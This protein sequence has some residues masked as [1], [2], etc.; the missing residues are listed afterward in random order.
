ME[1]RL[2][3]IC[4][5]LA[6]L[7]PVAG[8][9]SGVIWGGRSL[10]LPAFGPADS[11][12]RFLSGLLC[13]IGIGFWT[14]IPDI[15]RSG[16]RFQLLTILIVA[17]GFARALGLFLAGPAGPLMTGALSLELVIAPALL[18]WQGRIQRLA[19]HRAAPTP[20]DAAEG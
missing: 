20:V 2:L 12:V 19:E 5:A 8:G 4:V 17:G 3:Q 7:V 16:A 18:L 14:T 1:K 15:E 6:A 11:Q 10:G 9:M 13:A